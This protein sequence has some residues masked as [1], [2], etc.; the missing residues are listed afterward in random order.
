MEMSQPKDSGRQRPAN[1]TALRELIVRRWED[2]GKPPV[3]AQLFTSIQEHVFERFAGDAMSPASIARLLG[4]HGAEL[5]HPAIIEFDAVWREKQIRN[6]ARN[7][8]ELNEILTKGRMNLE[9]A[10]Q[11]IT[12]LETLRVEFA[13]SEDDSALAELRQHALEARQFVQ[14]LAKTGSRETKDR[15][16]KMEIDEWLKV[17]LQ[18]PVLFTDWLELRR[19]SEDF[20]RRFPVEAP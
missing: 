2:L 19:R 7:F 11:F 10:E 9:Q 13:K 6:G 18:T 8:G 12:K 1:M 16:E 20:R 5:R 3:D 14:T 17:W 4:D 15:A